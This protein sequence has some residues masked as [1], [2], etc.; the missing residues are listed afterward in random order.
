[1]TIV[2]FTGTQEGMTSQQIA[3]V[4]EFMI[5]LNPIKA[6][7]GDCIGADAQF[8]SI[9][10]DLMIYIV[11]HPGMDAKGYSRKR[12]FG[13]CDEINPVL[14]YL[15]RNQNIVNECTILIAAPEGYLEEVRSGTWSTVRKARKANRALFIVFPDGTISTE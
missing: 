10:R 14:P 9:C 6:H 8:H 7:H 12:A 3:K 13:K 4:R 1:V 15:E 5:S 11:G 2:G